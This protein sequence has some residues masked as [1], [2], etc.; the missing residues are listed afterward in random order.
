MSAIS[1]Y[2]KSEFQVSRKQPSSS[3]GSESWSEPWTIKGYVQPVAGALQTT[4]GKVSYQGTHVL[5]CA[6]DTVIL[7][8]DRVTDAY[9][10]V[11][12]AMY[13]QV[14]GIAGLKQHMEVDLED[15]S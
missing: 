1:R 10:R 12:I 15:E 8:G 2:F 14:S 4:R 6:W 9:G 7:A 13:V 5:Y 3:F 11:M